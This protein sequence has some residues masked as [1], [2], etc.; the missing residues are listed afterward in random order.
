MRLCESRPNS[1]ALLLIIIVVVTFCWAFIRTES[2][3]SEKP[4]A[5]PAL[6]NTAGIVS[7]LSNG[8]ENNSGG[9]VKKAN[10]RLPGLASEM[11]EQNALTL[12]H[13]GRHTK[14]ATDGNVRVN[15]LCKD[16]NKLVVY[17]KLK[18]SFAA[19]RFRDYE[20]SVADCKL[21]DGITC[22]YIEGVSHEVKHS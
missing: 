22:S 16:Q 13:S 5:S 9:L 14:A 3:R 17:S 7:V 12:P 21:P 10:D 15:S 19:A 8:S 2:I 6:A 18:G 20:K 11:G 1:S 4:A